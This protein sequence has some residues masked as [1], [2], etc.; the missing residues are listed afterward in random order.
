VDSEDF[1]ELFASFSEDAD[2]DLACFD[3]ADF[4]DEEESLISLHI[5]LLL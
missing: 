5:F 2:M 1:E 3:D 4:V